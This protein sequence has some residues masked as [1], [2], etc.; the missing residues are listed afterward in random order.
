MTVV[1][2]RDAKQRLSAYVEKAQRDRVLITKHGRPAALV[3]GVQ[4]HEL[5]DLMTMANPRFWELIEG[6]RRG[7][8]TLTLE[9]VRRRFRLVPGRRRRG[10]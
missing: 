2:L 4:G 6:R 8:R 3:I 10:G 7:K 1:A 5:E 9:A